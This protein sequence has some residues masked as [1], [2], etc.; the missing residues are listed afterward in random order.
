M[1]VLL[2]ATIVLLQSLPYDATY[3]AAAPGVVCHVD[4]YSPNLPYVRAG[5]ECRGQYCFISATVQGD[6]YRGCATVYQDPTET[7]LMAVS[8]PS[9]SIRVYSS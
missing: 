7:R 9:S 5:T 4:Y 2:I 8:H 3:E 1:T 6:V